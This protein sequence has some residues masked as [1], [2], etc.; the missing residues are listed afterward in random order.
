MTQETINEVIDKLIGPIYPV[1]DSAIDNER[2]KN[3]IE[4]IHVLD[5]IN[6]D[7]KFIQN[8]WKNTHYGS[9]QP[10]IKLIETYF[11]ETNEQ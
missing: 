8:S 11:K 6:S 1:A 5:R 3:L 2:F 9:V 7:L 4:L 10:F